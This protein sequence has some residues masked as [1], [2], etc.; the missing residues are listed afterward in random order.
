MGCSAMRSAI[1][2]AAPPGR[3]RTIYGG[4][5]AIGGSRSPSQTTREATTCASPD[6]PLTIAAE[7]LLALAA[8]LDQRDHHGGDSCSPT[9]RSVCPP[10]PV[11]AARP[12][13]DDPGSTPAGAP[14]AAPTAPHRSA[15]PARDRRSGSAAGGAS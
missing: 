11:P 9:N 3:R 12:P 4:R 6:G 7:A 15:R 1:S 8:W 14:T 13:D 5:G 2:S 10:A